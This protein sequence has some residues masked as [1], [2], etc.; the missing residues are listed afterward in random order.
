MERRSN[1]AQL[2]SAMG[3]KGP[4]KPRKN[5]LISKRRQKRALWICLVFAVI[6]LFLGFQLFSAK[7]Q[8]HRVNADISE[9]KIE[10]KKQNQQQKKLKQRQQ[11]LNNDDYVKDLAHSKYGYVKKGETTYHFVNK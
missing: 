10:V 5:R 4:Q 8:L 2:H 7:S 1:V 11:L 3:S 6:L 9:K